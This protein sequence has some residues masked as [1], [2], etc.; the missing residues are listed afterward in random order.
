MPDLSL[1]TTEARNLKSEHIDELS[2]LEML[3][4]INREDAT[5]ATAVAS[6][7]PAIAQAVDVEIDDV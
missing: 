6:Q 1:P 5:V 7:L 4:V 2:T 3:T